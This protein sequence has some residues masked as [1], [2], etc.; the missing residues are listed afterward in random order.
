MVIYDDK[1]MQRGQRSAAERSRICPFTG[2]VWTE[3]AEMTKK[4]DGDYGEN[5]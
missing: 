1:I 5:N 4:R 3:Q 2:A